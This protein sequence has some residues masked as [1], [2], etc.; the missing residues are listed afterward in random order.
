MDGTTKEKI[1]KKV[2]DRKNTIEQLDLT[3]I[4]KTT[5]TTKAEYIIYSSAYAIFS[6]LNHVLSHRT[7]LT[8]FK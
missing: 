6:N 8:R 7:K 5:H 2:K 3:N 1:N 4:Q